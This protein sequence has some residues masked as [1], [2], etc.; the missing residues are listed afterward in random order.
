[1]R[2]CSGCRRSASCTGSAAVVL[3]ASHGAHD[4][5][6]QKQPGPRRTFLLQAAGLAGAG[7]LGS[8]GTVAVQTAAAAAPAPETIPYQSLS[9][10]E[11]TFIEALVDVLCPA[12]EY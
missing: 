10:A 4:M 8:A 6:E 11:A 7:S 3:A 2:A 12:D 9:P 1:M 5:A